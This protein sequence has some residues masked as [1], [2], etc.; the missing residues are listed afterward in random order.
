MS[1]RP[2][3]RQV[4]GGLDT[5]ADRLRHFVRAHPDPTPAAVLGAFGGA[6]ELEDTVAEWLD[7][8]VAEQERR[9]AR[10]DPHREGGS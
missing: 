4:A 1:D 7:E 5:T 8:Y 3:A 2:G 9:R 6:P 10:R